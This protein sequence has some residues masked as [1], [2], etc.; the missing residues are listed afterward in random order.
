ME[1]IERFCWIFLLLSTIILS[2]N[3]ISCVK[4]LLTNQASLFVFGDSIFDVGNNN[5]INTFRAAQANFCPYGQ[6]TFKY[7]TGRHSDGRLIPNFIDF[8]LITLRLNPTKS[9]STQPPRGFFNIFAA[10]A[11][12][13]AWLPLIPPYLQPGNGVNQFT[14][15]VNFASAGARALVETYKPHNVIS[16]GSQLNNFE[17]V[18]KML[19]DR[20][21]DAET[22]RIISRAVYLIHIGPN[23]YFYSFSVNASN[24]Q[25]KT[26][27]TFVD[28]VIGIYKIGGKNFGI[29]NIGRIDCIP[30]LLALDPAR[31]GSLSAAL[32]LQGHV[33]NP[34]MSL[35]NFTT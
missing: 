6:T 31:I 34:S 24:F 26:K 23:D 10:S 17:N 7:P 32:H 8:H 30:E 2:N 16:L 35:Q 4:R 11:T 19:K 3:L 12:E 27:D 13:Y 29:M 5:Y 18:E 28:Y 15:G 9:L 1:N 21:G 25:S 22:K 14:Y 20:L 33:S